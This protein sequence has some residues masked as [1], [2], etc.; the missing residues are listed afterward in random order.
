MSHQLLKRVYVNGFV[1]VTYT[2]S[3]NARVYVSAYEQWQTEKLT[4]TPVLLHT[5]TL[6]A[7]QCS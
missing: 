5:Y 4:H 7:A 2:H 3:L 6:L 1:V